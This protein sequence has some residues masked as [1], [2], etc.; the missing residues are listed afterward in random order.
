MNWRLWSL[1][2]ACLAAF[3][4]LL[5]PKFPLPRAVYRYV[6]VID[7]TQ[8]MNAP[9][10][11]LENLPADRLGFAKEALRQAIRELPC[12]SEVGLGLFT[13]QNSQLLFQPMEVCEHLAVIDD[14]LAHLDWRMAWAANSQIAQGLY[15][16]LRNLAERDAGLKLVFLSDGQDAPPQTVKRG[17]DGRPGEVAGLIVGVGSAQPTLLPKYDRE[18]HLLGYWENAEVNAM[19]VADTDDANAPAQRREGHYQSWLDEARLL[20]LSAATGLRYHRLA[21]PE[22]LSKQLRDDAFAEYRIGLADVRWLPA[23]LALVLLL[24]IHWGKRRAV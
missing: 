9:D 4:A 6:F 19:P 23:L 14:T 7:I 8:S 17:Y 3:A 2:A 1:A 12:G 11:R 22:A 24:G 16:A 10:Y 5:V 20:E 18:N 15:S 13:T 21:S